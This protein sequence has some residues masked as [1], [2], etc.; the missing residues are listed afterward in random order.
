[1]I[2]PRIKGK[3][4]IDGIITY[5]VRSTSKRL[6]GFARGRGSKYSLLD[7]PRSPAL[8]ATDTCNLVKGRKG[9]EGF[10]STYAN[11]YTK[12]NLEMSKGRSILGE[13][14]R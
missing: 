13:T 4:S 9:F 1:M 11:L 8:F 12:P 7:L 14:S 2:Q 5:L 3:P 10:G 6:Q